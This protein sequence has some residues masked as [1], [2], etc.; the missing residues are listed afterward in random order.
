VRLKMKRI[1]AMAV[2]ALLGLAGAGL[3]EQ[4]EITGRLNESFPRVLELRAQGVLGETW[5][6]Y[7]GA[8]GETSAE[9][10][11]VMDGVNKDRRRLYELIAAKEG[12]TLAAVEER[13]GTRNGQRLRAGDLFQTR[14][15]AWKRRT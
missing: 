12:T 9:A 8:P 13:A 4:Q 10:R 7:L 15:G 5:Q 14:D 3:D 2:V 11:G 1:M 6:G